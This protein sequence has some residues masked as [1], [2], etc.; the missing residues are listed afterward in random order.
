[1]I[2]SNKTCMIYL[3]AVIPIIIFIYSPAIELLH[4]LFKV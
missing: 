4:V 2:A 1:M 3:K